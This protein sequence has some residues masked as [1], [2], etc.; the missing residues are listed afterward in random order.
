MCCVRGRHEKKYLKI[1][2]FADILLFLIYQGMLSQHFTEIIKTRY[3]INLLERQ[4]SRVDGFCRLWKEKAKTE[5][6][7]F[8]FYIL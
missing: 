7:F 5:H 3:P 6:K 8:E 1:R 4:H 2:E